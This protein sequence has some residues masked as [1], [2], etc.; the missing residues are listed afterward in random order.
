MLAHFFSYS[1]ALFFSV[2]NSAILFLH[3]VPGGFSSFF[4]FYSVQSAESCFDLFLTLF[5]FLVLSFKSREARA[6]LYSANSQQIMILL[7][8]SLTTL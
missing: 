8:N 4:S 5:I 7:V 2:S 1:L 6:F 3:L